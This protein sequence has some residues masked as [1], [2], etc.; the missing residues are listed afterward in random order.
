MKLD[1]IMILFTTEEKD[2]S[3]KNNEKD[4]NLSSVAQLKN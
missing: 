1:E 4:C 3:K 2:K